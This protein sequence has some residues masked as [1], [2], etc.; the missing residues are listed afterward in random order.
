VLR[1]PVSLC[2]KQLMGS[3]SQVAKRLSTQPCTVNSGIVFEPQ[4]RHCVHSV[5]ENNNSPRCLRSKLPLAE[6]AK[7]GATRTDRLLMRAPHYATSHFHS[8]DTCAHRVPLEQDCVR[9]SSS[10]LPRAE[11]TKRRVAWLDRVLTRSSQDAKPPFTYKRLCFLWCTA[12]IS[13]SSTE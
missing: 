2:V 8:Q 4:T 1:Y 3:V 9:H 5:P 6:A 13:Q 7:F 11:I 12:A 10:K